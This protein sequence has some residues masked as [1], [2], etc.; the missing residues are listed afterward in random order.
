M[1]DRDSILDALRNFFSDTSRS[2][3]ETLRDLEEIESE[4]GGYVC[5]LQEE[6]EKEAGESY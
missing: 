4:I 5:C 6:L 1:D 2:K 3:R